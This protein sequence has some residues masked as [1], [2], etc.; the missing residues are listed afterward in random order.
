MATS[1]IPKNSYGI[2]QVAKGFG[3]S[4]VTVLNWREGNSK[5][6]EVLPTIEK[7]IGSKRR[8]FYSGSAMAKWA[9]KNNATWNPEGLTTADVQG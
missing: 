5:T 8:V 9:K 2:E 4:T 7:T 1:T 3:V 6:R